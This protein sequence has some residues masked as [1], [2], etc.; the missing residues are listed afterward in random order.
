MLLCR[1]RLKERYK[2]I[3]LVA[4]FIFPY[5]VAA[6]QHFLHPSAF[7]T[8][9]RIN[10]GDTLTRKN[11]GRGAVLFSLV[12]VLPWTFDKYIKKADYAN[13]SFKTV[14]HNLN[15]GSWAWDNDNFQ[16]NQFG[17][18]YHGSHFYSAFRANGYSFWQSVPAVFAGSYIWETAAEKQYPAPNDFINTSFGGVILG[19]MTYRLS[20]K[21]INNHSRGFKRQAGEVVALLINPMNGITRIL[22]HKWGKVTANSRE[23]DSSKIYAEFD[24]GMRKVSPNGKDNTLKAYGHIKLL[25]GTP[26]ENYKVP[27][28]NITINTEIG[29]DDSSK[30]NTISVY[31]SL[32]GWRIRS[33]Q[34]L[35]HLAVL[36]A[37]YDYIHNQSFFYRA[38]SVKFNFYSELSVSGKIKLNTSFGAGPVILGAVPD[39]YTFNSRNYDYVSGIGYNAAGRLS[40]GGKF[41]YTL[42]YRGGWLTTINGNKS[43]YFLHTLSGEARYMCLNRFSIC[44][45]P[46]YFTLHGHY[47]NYASV[48][49]N[50]PY[51]RLSVRYSINIE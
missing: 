51:L 35:R 26:Y 14:A 2:I 29:Q 9:G 28:S 13:I 46:G 27:F 18:P 31:G 48:N 12:E 34:N 6:Q 15:P 3:I 43:Y 42:N 5:A 33:S 10:P 37:N 30:I 17:H 16:T 44:A 47:H 39:G 36:S 45:E 38:Q 22:D 23:Q 25:Y 32:N 19:E 41:F 49:K 1:I 7:S 24:L 8:S 21:I 40:I 11:F 50:Y 20:N 4:A